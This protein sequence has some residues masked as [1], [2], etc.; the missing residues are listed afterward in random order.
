MVSKASIPPFGWSGVQI[1][2]GAKS[3]FFKT[4][5]LALWST[6]DFCLKGTGSF[7]W[8]YNGKEI[9][10][11]TDVHLVVRLQWS[12]TTSPTICLHVLGIGSFYRLCILEIQS[13]CGH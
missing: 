4:P 3:F 6:Q 9:K 10:V 11:T 8:D 1:L 13:Q 7:S 5:T 2:V 12:Y